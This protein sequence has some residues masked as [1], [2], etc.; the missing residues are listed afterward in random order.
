MTQIE[1]FNTRI[2]ASSF[3]GAAFDEGDFDGATFTG[4]SMR[5]VELINCDVDHLVV[6]GVNVGNLL[7]LLLG[8]EGRFQP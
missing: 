4:C 3:E 2:H 7:R 6:N 8:E 5:G 1:A